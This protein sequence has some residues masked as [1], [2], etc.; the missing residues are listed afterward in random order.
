M[1]KALKMFISEEAREQVKQAPGQAKMIGEAEDG[2]EL[3][4]KLKELLSS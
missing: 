4:D 3:R 2:Q 1:E